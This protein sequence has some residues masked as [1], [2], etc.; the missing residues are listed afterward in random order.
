MELIFDVLDG[1]QGA[2]FVEK[3]SKLIATSTQN[4]EITVVSTGSSL[5][6]IREDAESEFEELA[7]TRSPELFLAVDHFR[8]SP[9]PAAGFVWFCADFAPHSALML[10]DLPLEMTVTPADLAENKRR[11]DSVYPAR[12]GRDVQQCARMLLLAVARRAT[13]TGTATT[14]LFV[15]YDVPQTEW[16]AAA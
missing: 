2:L 4:H 3:G 7:M 12:M 6:N 5:W 13:A 8:R 11:A 14:A 1:Q 16:D 10:T 9:P 15:K